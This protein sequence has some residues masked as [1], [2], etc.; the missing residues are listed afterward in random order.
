MTPEYE[1]QTIARVTAGMGASPNGSRL[2]FED[3]APVRQCY[4]PIFI[5][6]SARSGSTLLRRIIDA[7]P[8]VYSPAE[9]NIAQVFQ[10]VYLAV[11]SSFLWQD[12]DAW[13]P[14]H[15][16]MSARRWRDPRSRSC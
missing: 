2:H 8:A 9:T 14:R 12:D 5:L 4:D 15:R 7:H 13:K 10:T 16:S 3:G 6:T 1:L 11:A